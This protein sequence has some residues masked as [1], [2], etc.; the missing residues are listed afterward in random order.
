VVSRRRFLGYSA[1][2]LTSPFWAPAISAP[3]AS[4]APE[5]LTFVLRNDSGTTAH[6]YIA[7]FS[8]AQGKPVFVRQDGT[9]YFPEA[10]GAEPQPLDEDPSIA[11]DG[12]V[13][14]SVPRM[15]GARVYFVTDDKLEFQVA[16]AA[17][18]TTTVV[19]PD[20]VSDA[21]ANFGKDWTFAEFT[22]NAEQLY[23]N[24]SY[25][26]F[27]AAPVSLHLQAASGDQEVPGMPTGG[28]DKVA[29][30][31]R[32]QGGSWPTL[33]Q[34]ADGAV[35]RVLNPNHRAGEFEGYLEPYV[36]EVYAK[37]AN[38]TLF[39]DTQ[40]D[41]IGILEGRVE[42][43]ELVFGSER[44]A[45]PSSVDIWGCNS[46]PFANN[47]DSDSPE[48]LAIVP[49]LAA[50]FNRT[51]LLIN[52]NQPHEEDPATFYDAEVTNHYARIVH[53]NLPDGKGYA[54]AYDDVSSDGGEDHSGKVNAGDPE[55]FTLTLGALR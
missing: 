21:D 14:V 4:A 22:L 25:V 19:H 18:G 16:A 41:D 15:Y 5:R 44:F 45:K 6:A 43:S 24:I 35:V 40:R 52:P 2:A 36:D 49:R 12:S 39:V 8:D 13:E 48:R 1:A 55:V 53:E 27:V 38:E 29:Q 17:D 31:L 51:T 37:Y 3:F 46:G 11:I 47:P 54:F 42:G 30:A 50:A 33:V 26:D 9:E 32:D 10:A 34:E 28:M 23:A 7:G 20:F